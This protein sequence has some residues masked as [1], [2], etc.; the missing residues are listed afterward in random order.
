MLTGKSFPRRIART[1]LL[2]AVGAASVV[3]AAAGAASAAEQPKN[4]VGGLSN[5]DGKGVG[6]TLDKASRHATGL[7]GRVGGNAVESTVPGAGKTLGKTAKTATP[8]AQEVAG[9]AAGQAGELL[10]DTAASATKDGLPV[11]G[12]SLG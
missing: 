4:P 12:L 9:G 5:L 6:N 7:A 2:T 10:G 11:G 8:A 3:G 1:A